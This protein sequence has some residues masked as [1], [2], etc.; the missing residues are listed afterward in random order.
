MQWSLKNFAADLGGDFTLYREIICGFGGGRPVESYL[1]ADAQGCE[2]SDHF[3]QAQGRRVRRAGTG[4]SRREG[5]YK[6]YYC[7][8]EAT[9]FTHDARDGRK[10]H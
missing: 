8:S 4:T 10:L 9:A 1:V 5:Y 7:K 3:G 2:V 6:E